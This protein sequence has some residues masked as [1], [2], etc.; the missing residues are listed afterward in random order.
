MKLA[1]SPCQ[2]KGCGFIAEHAK[3][4]YANAILGKHKSKVH[5]IVSPAAKYYK[6]ASRK[7][8]TVSQTNPQPQEV[9]QQSPNF[10]PNCGCGLRAVMVAMN[11][12]ARR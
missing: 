9:T 8:E 11:L 12:K 10:C 3:Q 7:S 5:G 4:G 2:V 6:G 1:Q